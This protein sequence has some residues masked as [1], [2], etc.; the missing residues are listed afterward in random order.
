MRPRCHARGAE[1][2]L[3]HAAL[4]LSGFH[5]L[6]LFQRRRRQRHYQ[7][8]GRHSCMMTRSSVD[9]SGLFIS[10][11][12]ISSAD[13]DAGREGASGRNAFPQVRA[14]IDLNT[15][16]F[17]GIQSHASTARIITYKMR[18]LPPVYGA[19]RREYIRRLRMRVFRAG[20]MTG[21]HTSCHR[22]WRR[23]PS[24]ENRARGKCCRLICAS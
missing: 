16:A 15:A 12:Y 3:L 17:P 9:D 14:D 20:P 13:F 24:R 5:M 1:M 19:G 10:S 18:K 7:D 21:Q 22:R 6:M 11:Q 4:L 8:D 2:T 23:R